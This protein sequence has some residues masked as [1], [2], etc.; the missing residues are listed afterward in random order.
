MHARKE[1]IHDAEW[2]FTYDAS[3]RNSVP[4]PHPAV[5]VRRRLE[6]ADDARPDG[7]DAPVF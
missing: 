7:D 5:G 6:R 3:A 2:R 1:R 4:S